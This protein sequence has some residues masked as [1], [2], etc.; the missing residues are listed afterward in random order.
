MTAAA[1][2][3]EPLEGWGQ[4]LGDTLTC[5]A[6]AVALRGQGVL[7]LGPAGCGKS[8]LALELMAFGAGLIADDQV[9]IR[10]AEGQAWLY[11]PAR[12]QPMIEAR[13]IGL[14]ATAPLCQKAPLRLAVDLAR[15]EP[16]RLPPHRTVVFQGAT[17]PLILGHGNATLWA[18]LL[19]YLQGGRAG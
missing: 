16:A 12:A 2:A 7:L 5:H 18:A 8:A 3:P 19:Q 15:P 9:E 17:A 1:P 11:P 14:L 4:A 6:S 13:H 10:V